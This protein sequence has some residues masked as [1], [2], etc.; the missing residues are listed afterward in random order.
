MHSP[1]MQH[2]I[3]H[4]FAQVCTNEAHSLEPLQDLIPTLAS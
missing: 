2:C 1:P 3:L 4:V